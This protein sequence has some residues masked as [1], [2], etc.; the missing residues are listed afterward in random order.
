[1]TTVYVSI[2][3]SDDKL[4]QQRWARFVDTTINVIRRHATQI[5]GEWL[6]LPNSPWQNACVCF[7]IA[8]ELKDLLVRELNSLRIAYDQDSIA[9]AAATTTFIRQATHG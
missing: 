4:T 7:E 9:W 5:Y 2:G 8:D 6:S 1:M 3:N